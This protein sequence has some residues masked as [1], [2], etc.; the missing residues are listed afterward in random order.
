MYDWSGVVPANAAQ[1][2][3]TGLVLK[4]GDVI[5]IIAKGWVYYGGP[6]DPATAPQGVV[7]GPNNSEYTL[8]AKIG[9]KTYEVGNGLLHKTV[10]TDGELILLFLDGNY[11]DNSG[12]FNVD[13]KIESRYA[14]DYLTEI[15]PLI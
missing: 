1:G 13:V 10:P 8:V 6:G 15:K 9:D 3:P 5:S 2:K 11:A 7:D 14:P 12:V 4:A